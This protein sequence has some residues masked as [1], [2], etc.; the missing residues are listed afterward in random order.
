MLIFPKML[1][2]YG[3][4]KFHGV[5]TRFGFV[6]LKGFPIILKAK[7]SRIILEKGCVLVSKIKFNEA[8]INHPVILS[9]IASKAVLKIGS[10]GLSG[11]SICAAKSISIGDYCALGVNSKIYD[12]DFHP[13]N[14]EARRMQTSIFDAKCKPVILHNDVWLG[15]D[16]IVLKGVE[17]G[18]GA[19]IGALSVVTKNVDPKTMVAGNP[20]R[21]VKHIN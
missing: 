13:L 15:A 10:S 7:G 11:T 2:D 20:A 21:L 19:V 16:S 12:T 14:S 1:I 17:I 8:G 3:Y 6:T 5:E 18:N 4:L 9:T